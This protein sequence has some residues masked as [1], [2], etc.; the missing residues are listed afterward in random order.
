[1]K[2]MVYLEKHLKHVIFHQNYT[3]NSYVAKKRRKVAGSRFVPS[4]GR[5]GTRSRPG[6]FRSLYIPGLNTIDRKFHHEIYLKF[7]GSGLPWT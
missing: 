5:N 6:L 3:C 1:M 7:C 2:N 4:S